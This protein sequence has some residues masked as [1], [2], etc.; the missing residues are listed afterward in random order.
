MPDELYERCCLAWAEQQ[1]ELLRRVAAGER[2]N[3][4]VDWAHVIEEI[5]DVGCR[6]YE[7][8]RAS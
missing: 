7:A 1:S 3:A 5:H 6:S 8:A 4:A 2:V